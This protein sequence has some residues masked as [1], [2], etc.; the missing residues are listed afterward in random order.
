MICFKSNQKR[1]GQ[2]L[3]R[4]LGEKEPDSRTIRKWRKR[5]RSFRIMKSR[6]SC[7]RILIFSFLIPRSVLMRRSWSS[8]MISKRHF[9]KMTK[10]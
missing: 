5:K 9:S 4:V 6:G 1:R 8:F 3:L 2:L 10:R 7:R